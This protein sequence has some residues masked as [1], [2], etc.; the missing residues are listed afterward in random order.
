[1]GPVPCLRG[2]ARTIVGSW[3][4]WS[5]TPDTSHSGAIAAH[6]YAQIGAE[7]PPESVL[8]LG[9]DHYGLSEGASLS[10]RPWLTPIGPT[11][12]DTDLVRALDVPPLHIDEA[13]H[14]REHSI[15]VQLPFLEYVLPKPRFVPLEVR[16]GP[17]EYLEEVAEV[18]RK[19][20]AGR[21]VLLLASTDFSHYV[22][23]ATA[24]RLDR[25]AIDAILE[26]DARRLY[27]TVARTRHLDVWD[28]SDHRPAG[29]A[30]RAEAHGPAPALGALGRGR[31]LAPGR[32]VR[33]DRPRT[34]GRGSVVG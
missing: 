26:R 33:G 14:A 15:E 30:L 1:M 6:V 28:R 31:A 20:I 4:P 21:D 24:Q 8:V 34:L 25:L 3:L 11:A 9:V 22:S 13:A 19:A 23:P 7:R 27:Q 17:E 12:I 10:A 18:V 16:F 29:R 32:G 5:P 2:I